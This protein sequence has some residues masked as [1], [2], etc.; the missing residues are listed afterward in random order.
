MIVTIANQKGGVGKTTTAVHL[1]HGLAIQ[2]YQ[3]LAI[4]LDPQGH[5]AVSLGLD[6]GQGVFDWLVRE[7]KLKDLVKLS[8]R[9]RLSVLPGNKKTASAVSYLVLEHKGAV[10]LDL[11]QVALRPAL[12][13]GLDY[14]VIDTAP[15]ASELQ[16]AAIYAASVMVIPAACDYLSQDGVAQTFDTYD[17]AA[18]AGAVRIGVL[19]TFYDDRTNESARILAEYQ[20]LLGDS[21]TVLPPIHAA[22]RF[23]EAAARG[24]TIYEVEPNGRGARE[25]ANLVWWIREGRDG[26]A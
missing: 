4:D 11:L 23:R 12:K 20:Q 26:R 6:A 8:G 7:L 18:D 9:P 1:A 25:Y 19:P 3:V 15:S 14:V 24:K 5:V 13:N 22:T 10:P 21:A 17:V 16:A 2:G